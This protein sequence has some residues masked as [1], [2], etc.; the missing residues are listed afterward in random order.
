[1]N[2]ILT[3][4]FALVIALGVFWGLNWPTVK[5]LLSELPPWTLRSLG[6][7]FGTIGLAALAMV[8]GQSLR[9]RRSADDIG[10]MVRGNLAGQKR[11]NRIV[12]F[13]A[14]QTNA[15]YV[16]QSAAQFAIKAAYRR[17]QQRAAQRQA[18][19]AVA[20]VFQG[21]MRCPVHRSGRY[22]RKLSPRQVHSARKARWAQARCC[23][24][25]RAV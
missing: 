12:L 14:R 10:F 4:E 2:R 17:H 9:P 8:L 7:G 21:K 25:T 11:A 16:V 6:L 22:V 13:N 19:R 5:V 15:F 18:C 1:M 23:T 3:I 20:P 24:A